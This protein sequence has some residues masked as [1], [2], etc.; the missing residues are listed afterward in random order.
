M[1]S[2]TPGTTP[3]TPQSVP[4]PRDL[5]SNKAAGS[6]TSS[7]AQNLLSATG[8]SQ[9]RFT[10][11]AGILFEDK[12]V[13]YIASLAKLSVLG[14]D[15]S[16]DEMV[17]VRHVEDASRFIGT[18]PAKHRIWAKIFGMVGAILFGTGLSQLLNMASDDKYSTI[19]VWGSTSMLLAGGV[20][21][22]FH[23]LKE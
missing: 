22:T 3:S 7:A 2:P 23:I 10:Q 13:R 18:G 1:S 9:P 11:E 15:R 14:A 6:P 5:A 20:M 17:S 21:A 16:S 12:T 8:E 19:G 4:P